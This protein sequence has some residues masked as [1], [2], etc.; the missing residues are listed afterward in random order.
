MIVVKIN[1]K[2][3]EIWPPK[4]EKESKYSNIIDKPE[5]E[6]PKFETEEEEEKQE[7]E[8]H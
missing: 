1:V 6:E 2:S 7:E 4:T 8:E 3:D 5:V